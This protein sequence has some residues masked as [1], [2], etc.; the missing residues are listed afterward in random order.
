[1][2][3]LAFPQKTKQHITTVAAFVV[4]LAIAIVITGCG[5]GISSTASST[6][7]STS[8]PTV[9]P[10][11]G[12]TGAPPTGPTGAPPTGTTGDPT[13][14]STP[15]VVQPSH[16]LV[17]VGATDAFSATQGNTVVSGGQWMVLGGSANGSI[18]SNGV[19]H[20]P[21]SMPS[22]AT[23]AV[24][25]VL[26]GATYTGTVTVVA[27]PAGNPV[28]S[29]S[30]TI[31][32]AS[33]PSV[34]VNATDAFS[35]TQSGTAVPGGQWVILGGSANGSIDP[36]GVF[37]APAS[38]PSPATIS[39]GFVLGSQIYFGTVTVVSAPSTAP[40]VAQPVIQT[41][42]PS[43][44]QKLTTTVEI[45]GSGFTSTSVVTLNASPIPTTYVDTGHL[46]AVVTL[47]NPISATLQLAVS[48]PSTA[49]GLS[50]AATVTA[51]FPT[52]SVQPASLAVGNVTL[53]VAGSNFASGY[54][55]SM[56][57]VPLLTTINS[58]TKLTAT[59]YLPP[60]TSGS[61]VVEVA[62]GS[63]TV[64]V[65][66]QYVT[67]TPTA[68][69]FDAAARFATQA[70]MGPRPDVVLHIQQV[71]FDQFITEQFQQPGV[72]YPVNGDPRAFID[73]AV[74]GNSLLR[75][76]VALGLQSFLVSQNE[77]FN[78]SATFYESTLEADA[79]GNF[80]QLLSDVV[81]NPNIA[82]FLNVLGNVAATNGSLVQPN[83]NFARELMQLFS[84]G[85]M[86]LNDDGSIQTD[87]GGNPIPT[88]TQNT[89]IDLT[90]AFTGWTFPQ[91]VNPSA[92]AWGI[93]FSQPIAPND[94][95]HDHNAKLL[96]GSVVLPAGQSITQD[97]NMA[98][99]AIFNHPNL[100][101]YISHLMIQ[102]LVTSNP[103]PAYIARMSKVFE[104]DGTGVRGN[105]QALVRAI[106]LDPE[107]RLGDTQ[108]S[109]N[110]GFLQEP[111]LFQLFA[112]SALQ[113]SP[114]DDQ[115]NG[116]AA[117]FG[118]PWW[119]SPTVFGYYTP[120]YNVPGTTINSPEFM[121]WNNV[122]VLQRSEALWGIVEQTFP[123]FGGYVPGSWLFQNFTT[124]PQMTDALNHLLY[125]G[126]MSQQ[127]QDAI[128][129]Y[130][131]QLNPF[132]TTSQLQAAVF[133]ALN[134]DSYNVSH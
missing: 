76:R 94:Q 120:T 26:A 6:G 43:V 21:A 1:V 79:S 67:I 57:G 106:L 49:G 90:R 114:S 68:V 84:L 72:P 60:W 24:G 46:E 15:T 101:P 29:S 32:Q 22:P 35:A 10:P 121:L 88:Y 14:N 130:C 47:Q 8:G 52:I 108:P 122:S 109:P 105:M 96:F 31:V 18:D 77:D 66:A 127:Q 102:R 12:T 119:N 11:T 34:Q 118:E 107:A 81:S 82:S 63:G 23:V 17:Q 38:V 85:T 19:F 111:L 104:N 65:S 48:N 100:P 20:A 56:G 98:L 128:A 95:Q 28:G 103:S 7:V 2:S 97:R 129:T 54:V 13:G 124:V 78:P 113:D 30:A 41:V 3:P 4:F 33:Q 64:P 70:A 74:T 39:V 91:Q 61:V 58:S 126:Q 132:D 62:S 86:M 44:L 80:R 83:Q 71:G 117:E 42:S 25:Y 73:G 27:G 125:H 110:D 5:S 40:P 123:G 115:S 9:A 116:L 55:V 69:S 92:V 93:D 45:A 131:S 16:P 99:D 37:H 53:T 50:A 87:S 51:S 112:M 133:L 36:N 75:Q 134:G 89:V 59:G